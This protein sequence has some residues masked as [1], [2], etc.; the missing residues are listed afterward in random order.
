MRTVSHEITLIDRGREIRREIKREKDMEVF[1]SQMILLLSFQLRQRLPA[2]RRFFL[3]PSGSN[4]F[5]HY[6]DTGGYIGKVGPQCAGSYGIVAGQFEGSVSYVLELSTA[7]HQELDYLLLDIAAL[8]YHQSV[9]GQ[10]Q[11]S[12]LSRSKI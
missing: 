1:V 11:S 9:Q 7:G 6:N 3:R 4:K 5:A 10:E 12:Q 8:V 2:S